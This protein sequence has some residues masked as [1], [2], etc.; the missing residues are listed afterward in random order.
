MKIYVR[1]FFNLVL[2]GKEKCFASIFQ[3]AQA[4]KK[5]TKNSMCGNP[6]QIFKMRASQGKEWALGMEQII[7]KVNKNTQ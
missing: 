7:V 6:L 5:A 3:K 1:Y 2:F 4:E